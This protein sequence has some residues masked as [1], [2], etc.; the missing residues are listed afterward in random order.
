MLAIPGQGKRQVDEVIVAENCV[1]V[2]EV[3]ELSSSVGLMEASHMQH[4]RQCISG[5]PRLCTHTCTL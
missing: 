2:L 3:S 4:Y 5:C 1:Q